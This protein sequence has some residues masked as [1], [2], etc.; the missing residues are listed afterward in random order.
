MVE[1][2]GIKHI[3]AMRSS[4]NPLHLRPRCFY[5]RP[6]KQRT[7]REHPYGKR[8]TK[9]NTIIS[10]PCLRNLRAHIPSSAGNHKNAPDSWL[11]LFL[12]CSKAPLG[13]TKPH[14]YGSPAWPNPLTQ[15]KSSKES[16]AES[17]VVRLM[18][19]TPL[20]LYHYKFL[21]LSPPL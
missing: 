9:M 12:L 10:S 14:F 21:C 2:I 6:R 5:P 16:S 7:I 11:N 15:G 13:Y 1:T 3:K 19:Q 4:L 18:P 17:L 8:R 20:T